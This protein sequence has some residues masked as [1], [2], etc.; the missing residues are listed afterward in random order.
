[1]M[2]SFLSHEFDDD[3]TIVSELSGFTQTKNNGLFPL[4]HQ[5]HFTDQSDII[6]KS[7]FI[8]FSNIYAYIYFLRIFE[9]LLR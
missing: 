8:F 7:W 1:M 3:S 9:F 4:V 2:A 5:F 6:V